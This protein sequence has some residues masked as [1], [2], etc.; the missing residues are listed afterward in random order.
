M[1]KVS[2]VNL[3]W[4]DIQ[5]AQ[6][7]LDKLVLHLSQCNKAEGKSPKTVAMILWACLRIISDVVAQFFETGRD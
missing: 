3:R 1:L 2:K 4:E 6:I 5:M 7:A